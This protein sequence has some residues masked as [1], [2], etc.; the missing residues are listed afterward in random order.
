M[1]SAWVIIR[2]FLA[3]LHVNVY[4]DRIKMVIKI[5]LARPEHRGCSK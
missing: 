2:S 1:R 3:L 5:R 4:A